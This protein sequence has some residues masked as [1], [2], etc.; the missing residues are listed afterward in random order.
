MPQIV[1]PLAMSG[2]YNQFLLPGKWIIEQKICRPTGIRLYTG[3]A[4]AG[5]FALPG[6]GGIGL[7]ADFERRFVSDVELLPLR[8]GSHLEEDPTCCT[9][10]ES[11]PG[12]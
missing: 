11:V 1:S 6:F 2:G 7:E 10:I 4:E 3:N 9:F 12:T 5:E 8:V